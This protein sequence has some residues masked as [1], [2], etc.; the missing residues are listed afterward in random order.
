M[1]TTTST[2][3]TYTLTTSQMDSLMTCA[4]A[5]FFTKMCEASATKVT[6]AIL[7]AASKTAEAVVMGINGDYKEWMWNVDVVNKELEEAGVDLS[8]IEEEALGALNEA[9]ATKH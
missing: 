2:E 8:K 7:K 6:P 4:C 9:S 5:M 1:T 3:K